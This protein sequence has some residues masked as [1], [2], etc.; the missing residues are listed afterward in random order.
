MSK[1]GD[2]KKCI[3]TSKFVFSN[4]LAVACQAWCLFWHLYTNPEELKIRF[5]SV[6]GD[7]S[8]V[9]FVLI[10]KDKRSVSALISNHRIH[11]NSVI[12]LWTNGHCAAT[13]QWGLLQCKR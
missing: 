8:D 12:S 2:E 9:H 10:G 6:V 11:G 3:P 1:C 13:V 5:G 7:R 4:D